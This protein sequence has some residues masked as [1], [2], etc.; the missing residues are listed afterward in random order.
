MSISVIIPVFN[1][2]KFIEKAVDSA[3]IQKEVSEVILIEDCS[4]DSSLS[5][6]YNLAK[7]NKIIKLIQHQEKCNKGV[8][9]SRNLGIDNANSKYI[10]FLDADDYYLPNR[11]V[12]DLQILE[13][14][15]DIDGV[16]NALE[17]FF[18]DE[19]ERDRAKSTITTFKSPVEPTRLFEEMAPIGSGGFFHGNSL[20]VRASIFSKVGYF[21]EDLELSQDTHMWFKMALGSTLVAGVLDR[22]L[23]MRGVHFGN[24]IRDKAKLHSLRPELYHSLLLWALH[25]SVAKERLNTIWEI[26]QKE[27]VKKINKIGKSKTKRTLSMYSLWIQMLIDNPG[28]LKLSGFRSSFLRMALL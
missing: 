12:N 10:A 19:E 5:I 3:A 1:A 2:D 22:P 24:R 21:N 9:A 13:N 25:N 14:N 11:F 6:C 17:S 28:L 8:G 15:T 27:L 20:T 26:Y 23:A 18:Y 7:N 4:H 16:Y